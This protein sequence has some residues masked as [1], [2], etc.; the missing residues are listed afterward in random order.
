[1]SIL[2]YLFIFIAAISAGIINALAGG[3]TLIT[4]PTLLALG[5]A[6][7]PANMTN[8]VALC[9]G[10]LGG[11]MAQVSDLRGQK[12]RLWVVI[13]AAILGG[14][15]G[16]ILL[17]QTTEKLFSNLVPF[18]ILLASV[19]LAVQTPL[20]TWLTRRGESQASSSIYQIWLFLPIFLGAIYGGYFGAGLSVILLAVL[21]LAL[22][23]SLTRL[24]ALKQ[25]IALSTNLIAALFFI[26]SGK[27]VWSVAVVMMV[28]ALIGGSLGGQLA[29]RVK[30]ATLRWIV[31]TIGFMVGA[32][33]L[34]KTFFII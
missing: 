12:K 34:V 23:D 18:M 25:S 5:L 15:T 8:T 2:H 24:N 27:V 33:Y 31:V 10:F 22:N 3:G 7:I 13:P 20:R 14:L 26:F 32:I 29:G 21:G 9:P 30:P 6:P 1:M 16:A 11:T 17:V 4:F 28:G 19:L